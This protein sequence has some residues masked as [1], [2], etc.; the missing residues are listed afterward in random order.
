VTLVNL[1]QKARQPEAETQPAR[2]VVDPLWVSVLSLRLYEEERDLTVK[3]LFLGLA[4]LGGY[5]NRSRDAWPGWGL[6]SQKAPP[7]SLH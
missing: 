3:Q 6:S 5:M 4:K 7:M 2:E 1:R